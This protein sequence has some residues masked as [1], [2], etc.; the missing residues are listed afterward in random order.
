MSSGARSRRGSELDSSGT[1]D[2]VAFD[3][4]RSLF[5][6]LSSHRICRH[7]DDNSR[8]TRLHDE[9]LREFIDQA[10]CGL[11]V[12]YRCGA[13]WSPHHHPGGSVLTKNE[14]LSLLD[15]Y[16]GALGVSRD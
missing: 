6:V 15:I 1:L 12:V 7:L 4:I 14:V 16:G 2:L 5:S 8:E 9:T 10:N 11:Q 13:S 3:S